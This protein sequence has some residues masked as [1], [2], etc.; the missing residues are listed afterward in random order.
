MVSDYLPTNAEKVKV[1]LESMMTVLKR[2][3]SKWELSGQGD[4]G[5]CAEDDDDDD[6]PLKNRNYTGN[7]LRD[8]DLGSSS[9][10]ESDKVMESVKQ[11]E[12][13]VWGFV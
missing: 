11:R 13:V 2:T 10:S 3:I 9:E 12:T 1:R 6:N 5:Q 7:I 8:C 4:G